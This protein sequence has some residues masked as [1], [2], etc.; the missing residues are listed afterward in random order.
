MVVQYAAV[1]QILYIFSIVCSSKSIVMAD[2]ALTMQSSFHRV[3]T[4]MINSLAW[5]RNVQHS[6]IPHFVTHHHS[7]H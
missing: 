2:N 1:R 5:R 4:S 6:H 3:Y 7:S